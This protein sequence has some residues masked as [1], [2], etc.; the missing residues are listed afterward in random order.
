[1]SVKAAALSP[2]GRRHHRKGRFEASRET[3]SLPA[4]GGATARELGHHSTLLGQV[5]GVCPRRRPSGASGPSRRLHK[6]R[7]TEFLATA[8]HDTHGQPAKVTDP[9][10]IRWTWT[11]DACG[12]QIEVNEPDKGTSETTY[13]NADRPVKSTDAR[14][15]EL[16]KMNDEMGRRRGTEAGLDCPRLMGLR[17]RGQGVAR[18]QHALCGRQGVRYE[19]RCLV[20]RRSGGVSGRWG[21]SRRHW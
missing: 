8:E 10:G 2:R 16:T 17:Q 7:A 12:R 3:L 20:P 18:T 9:A 15:V 21:T 6:W 5:G 14:G 13:D 19:N 1:M 11:F 4:P